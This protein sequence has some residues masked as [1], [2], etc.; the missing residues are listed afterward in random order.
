MSSEVRLDSRAALL[1][2]ELL[3]KINAPSRF[4]LSSRIKDD[5]LPKALKEAGIK[6]EIEVLKVLD[7]TSLRIFKVQTGMGD[8]VRESET[9]VALLSNDVDI[10]IGASFGQ[11][12]EAA[13][14]KQGHDGFT[15][16]P[17]R[18][19]RPDLLI[20]VKSDS[21]TPQWAPVDIKSHT[22]FE[23]NKSNLLQITK[24]PLINPAAG[25]QISG[26]LVKKDGRQLAHYIR[27]LQNLGFASDTPWGGILGKDD[28]FIA[29]A[30]LNALTYGVGQARM[31]A[32][33]QYDLAFMAAQQVVEGAIARESN[34]DS[35]PITIARRISGD[36]GCPT[37]EMRKICRKE[38]EDFDNR[39]GH[40]T[41][42]TD[43]TAEKASKYFPDIESMAELLKADPNDL[44]PQGAIA[45][46]RAHVWQTKKPQLIDPSRKF[47]IPEF[48]IEIDIDLENSQEALREEGFEETLGRDSVYLYGYGIHDRTVNKDWNSAK[49]GYF[50]D[51][52]DNDE[53]EFSVLSQMWQKLKDE[54]A[55]AEAAGKSVGIFHYSPHERTWWRNFI[56]RHGA[57]PGAPFI[58]E[59]ENFMAKY[60]IDLYPLAQHVALPVTGYS[61]KVL[62][63]LA[64]FEWEVK[65]AGGGNSIVYYQTATSPNKSDDEKAIAIKWL[66]EYNRDDVKATFAARAYLRK[67]ASEFI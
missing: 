50:D 15:G 63:P 42:L 24:L 47:E 34:P 56:K 5:P 2:H 67:L 12:L 31:G 48:D 22:A 20:R 43:I 46:L 44:P 33:Q 65:D 55:T 11:Y 59:I 58:E 61:I 3:H 6:Y 49:F 53:A 13:L 27:H 7:E 39:A 26:T 57:K 40:V 18:V 54:V 66:R 64:G 41:L 10:I 1:C 17:F 21:D 60:F 32:L 9:A 52:R 16:D 62:A 8:S 30:D 29:W 36:F 38:L 37:C 4:D 51:Y 19:S 28:S 23:E 45:Q 25:E 35:S 14:R